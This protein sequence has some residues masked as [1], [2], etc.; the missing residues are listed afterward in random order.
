LKI[1]ITRQA[2]KDRNTM[3]QPGAVLK[4]ESGSVIII[5]MIILVLLT[6]IGVAAI[7]TSTTEVQIASNEQLHKIAFYAADG[8]T[9]AGIKMLVKNIQERDWFDNATIE[10]IQLDGHSDNGTFY[11]NDRSDFGIPVSDDNRDAFLPAAY[12][13]GESHTNL[14]FNGSGDLSEGTATQL[15][16]GYDG[17]GKGAAS[18][19]VWLMYDVRAQHVGVRNS[20]AL[21]HVQYRYVP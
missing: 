4:N 2:G 3:R 21:V 6:I 13:T 9:E 16:S 1:E 15:V 7:N 19:G 8:G 17:K 18:G 11:T 14:K 5:A 12:S 20:Q 10:G